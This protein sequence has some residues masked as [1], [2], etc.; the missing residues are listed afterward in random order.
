MSS[1]SVERVPEN[2]WSYLN[3]S[4]VKVW[5]M[6]GNYIPCCSIESIKTPSMENVSTGVLDKSKE[7]YLRCKDKAEKSYDVIRHILSRMSKY[8]NWRFTMVPSW[9]GNAFC[10]SSVR[11][12]HLSLR[13]QRTVLR[14]F[15][16][17]MLLAW[18]SSF[19]HKN[20]P[21]QWNRIITEF[22]AATTNFLPWHIKLFLLIIRMQSWIHVH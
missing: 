21:N 11:R 5:M 8:K 9:Q 15:D 2:G 13:H 20:C 10:I 19:P 18:T 3:L 6:R 17:L 16:V 1:C 22:D 12:I 14:S 7:H 4:W